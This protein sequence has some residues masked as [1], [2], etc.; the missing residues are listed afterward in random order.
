MRSRSRRCSAVS[1]GSR[2]GSGACEGSGKAGVAGG[3]DRTGGK[4]GL[5]AD[6]SPFN[7][8]NPALHF[9]RGTSLEFNDLFC[10]DHDFLPVLGIAR[11]VCGFVSYGKSSEAQAHNLF[12]KL[13]ELDKLGAKTV[14]ARCPDTTG[15]GLAVYNRLIRS[16]GFKIIEL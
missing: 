3:P 1:A 5:H 9:Q 8:H 15:V 6:G 12:K 10:F 14:Y 4:K 13:R 11:F 16:A 7:I 2:R